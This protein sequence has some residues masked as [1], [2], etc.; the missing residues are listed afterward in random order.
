MDIVA[1]SATAT[2]AFDFFQQEFSKIGVTITPRSLVQSTLINNVIYGEYDCAGWNQFGGVDQ[3]LNY[4]WFDSQPATTSPTAGG[5]G[6]SG[7]PAGTQIAGAVNFAHQADPVVETALLTA[8]ASRVGSAAQKAAWQAV[9]RRFAIDMPYI[10][11]DAL[12]NAW[13]ARSDVQNWVS[14]TAGDGTTRCLSP[15]GDSARWDQIWK[16]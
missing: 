11:L 9:N 10:M 14:G 7:L 5:L 6:M 1:G 16:S 3:S 12:V 8:L 2:K 4:V 13:A 15:D